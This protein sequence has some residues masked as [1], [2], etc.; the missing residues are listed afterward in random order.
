[1]TAS[2]GRGLTV[3]KSPTGILPEELMRPGALA[4]VMAWLRRLPVEGDLKVDVLIGWAKAV[5]VKV[6]A[7]QRRAVRESGIDR[8]GIAAP[9]A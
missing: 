3:A 6:N 1:M 2:S 4:G 9:G 5:G 7:A 8:G